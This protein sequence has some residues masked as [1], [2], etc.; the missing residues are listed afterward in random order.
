MSNQTIRK[1]ISI[2]G[3]YA[4]FWQAGGGDCRRTPPLVNIHRS[5]PVFSL[6]SIPLQVVNPILRQEMIRVPVFKVIE[7]DWRE[8]VGSC[9][10]R[11]KMIRVHKEC[12]QKG[13]RGK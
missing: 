11:M 5:L 13:G 1:I 3:H 8:D 12:F 6:E 10:R 9:L 7:Y 4:R 2:L